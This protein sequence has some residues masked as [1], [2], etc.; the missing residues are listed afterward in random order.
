MLDP[1]RLPVAA[2]LQVIVAQQDAGQDAGLGEDLEAVARAEDRAAR[3]REG[4]DR[5]HHRREAS[6][7]AG[8][9]VVAVGKAARQHDRVGVTEVDLRMPHESR[10]PAD[11]AGDMREV[12]V[13][14]GPREDQH[15]DARGAAHD[16]IPTATDS[17]ARSS[18]SAVSM[19]GLAR[20]RLHIC[21]TAVLGAGAVIRLERRPAGASRRARRRTSKPSERSPPAMVC[22][23][24][25]AIPGRSRT[26][27]SASHR[28]RP[29]ASP[30]RHCVPV[31]RS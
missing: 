2:E 8:A 28:I 6:D 15:G 4:L 16:S 5:G 27:T 22:P 20:S 30:P 25:S 19:T 14:P 11:E 21:A 7:C 24:G 1:Q 10:I 3:R 17:S 13:A 26:W 23:S 29:I 18:Q 31:S 9:Q 12:P